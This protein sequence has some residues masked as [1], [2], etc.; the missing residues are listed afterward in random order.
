VGP[1]ATL[2]GIF[3]EALQRD[4]LGC[5]SRGAVDRC[6]RFVAAG[7][8]VGAVP[9][10]FVGAGGGM[11]QVYRATD[12]RLTR[13]PSRPA[14]VRSARNHPHICHLYDVGPNYL[15]MEFVEA[16]PLRGRFP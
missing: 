11:G 16:T 2:E 6:A 3:H 12:T 10:R 5:G 15:V 4:P 13:W 14:P 9:H 8:I 1:L 7:P